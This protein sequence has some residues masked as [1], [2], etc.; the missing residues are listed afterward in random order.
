MIDISDGCDHPG[1]VV[2]GFVNPELTHYDNGKEV[3]FSCR[4]SFMLDGQSK[5]YC[6]DENV[7]SDSTPTCIKQG[8]KKLRNAYT[9]ND[10]D[11]LSYSPTIMMW[12]LTK[13]MIWFSA[14]PFKLFINAYHRIT[15]KM[16][17]KL[18]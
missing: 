12:F 15:N 10:N 7:W 5:V 2:N 9:R 17:L 18:T 11:M 1:K 8:N 16:D 3:E 14:Y 4:K 6:T 13:R